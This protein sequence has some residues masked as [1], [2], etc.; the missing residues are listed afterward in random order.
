[1]SKNKFLVLI[2]A[3]IVCAAGFTGNAFANGFDQNNMGMRG[4]AM[5]SAFTGVADDATAIYYNPGGMTAI[6]DGTWNYD[7]DLIIIFS[8]F[9]WEATN[10]EEHKSDEME[11]VPGLYV[12]TSSGDLSYGIGIYAPYGGGTVK[13]DTGFEATIAYFAI[14][15]SIAYKITPALSAGVGISV[16]YGIF[17]LKMPGMGEVKTDGICG[18]SWDAGLMYKAT[19]DLNLGLSVKS[20]VPIKM[21]GTAEMGGSKNDANVEFTLPYYFI[22]G[23]GYKV[24]PDILIDADFWYM[25]WKKMDE[26]T[27]S[28]DG[29][30]NDI[31]FKTYYGNSYDAMIGAEYSA[32]RDLRINAGFK[33][34]KQ[35]ASKDE[36]VSVMLNCET[37]RYT[38]VAGLGYFIIENLEISMNLAF[39]LGVDNKVDLGGTNDGTYSQAH[40]SITLG[41]RGNF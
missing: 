14:T 34:E 10:G 26:I 13:Y 39:V 38:F 25:Q 3:L 15:P 30:P 24:T 20:Q 27:L 9:M 6:K 16:Y 37:N 12:V 19:T 11:Y 17:N 41:I 4:G 35:V 1:M 32:S 22:A 33:Y 36:G 5:A 28:V 18:W 23:I 7:A 40:K 31:P 2:Y 8:D 21:K 29:V